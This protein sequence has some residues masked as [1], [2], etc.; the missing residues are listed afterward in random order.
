MADT[1]VLWC[2]VTAA[3]A[4]ASGS[5]VMPPG[6][7][8]SPVVHASCEIHLPPWHLLLGIAID[9]QV[10]FR[11]HRSGTPELAQRFGPEHLATR[12]PHDPVAR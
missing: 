2:G 12:R 3:L 1:A 10:L 9:L 7:A 6:E 4:P 8:V 5:P 11:R